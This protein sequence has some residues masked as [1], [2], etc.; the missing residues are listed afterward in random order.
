MRL[1]VQRVKK[2]V[3]KIVDSGKTMGQIEK[4]LFV[5]VGVKKGDGPSDAEILAAKLVKLRVMSDD[6]DKMN[7]SVKDVGASLLV[8]S[9]FTLYSD[10]SGGNRPSFIHAALPD[11][12]RKVYEHFVAKLREAGIKVETGNFGAYMA[13]EA[14]LDGPVTILL[15]T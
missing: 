15:E 10:T 7:L 14:S 4:G 3:V 8:V 2:A 11:E 5:L 12:A 9:Q 6:Q 13:I 1:V